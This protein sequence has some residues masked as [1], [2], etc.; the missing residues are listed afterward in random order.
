[1]SGKICGYCTNWRCDEPLRLIGHCT[2]NRGVI[3]H[4]RICDTCT[5]YQSTW[6]Y[7]RPATES[8]KG[9]AE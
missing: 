4:G 3:P 9:G 1:M 6:E 8:E 2:I 5:K 7:T